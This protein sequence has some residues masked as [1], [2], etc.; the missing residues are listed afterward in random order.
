M[1]LAGWA[2]KMRSKIGRL[3]EAG[4]IKGSALRE[5]QKVKDGGESRRIK[6]EYEPLRNYLK[7]TILPSYPWM[8]AQP[9]PRLSRRSGNPEPFISID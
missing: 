3:E 8:G 1:N 9:H 5:G 2:V 4:Y 6:G 7:T